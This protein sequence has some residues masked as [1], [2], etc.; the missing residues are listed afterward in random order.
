VLTPARKTNA[1]A[2]SA[3]KVVF[4]VMF[5]LLRRVRYGQ[6]GP[7]LLQAFMAFMLA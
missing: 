7:A 2:V 5:V 3:S 6:R 1:A 4:I